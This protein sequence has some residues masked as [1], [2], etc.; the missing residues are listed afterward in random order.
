MS[1]NFCRDDS[2]ML[3]AWG[4]LVKNGDKLGNQLVVSGGCCCASQCDLTWYDELWLLQ[5]KHD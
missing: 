5:P 1:A 3:D 2:N 4:G